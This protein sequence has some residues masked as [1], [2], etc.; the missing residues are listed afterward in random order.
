MKRL[1]LAAYAEGVR[2]RDRA[3]LGRAI[4]LIESLRADDAALAQALLA[5]LLPAT[6]RAVRVGLSG[7][8]GVGKSTFL[9][10]LGSHLLAAGRK[11]A[12]L[13]V[14]PSSSRSGGSILGDKT[15]MPRLAADEAAFVR[16]SP[17]GLSLGGVAR[18]TRE[19]L[20]LCEAA[21]HDVVL[22]ETVGVGQSEVAVADMVDVFVVLMLPGAGD[23]LQ[24]IKKGILEL[25]DLVVVNK[26]DGDNLSRAH[27]AE[28]EYR[29]AL[30]YASP[31]RAS[32]RPVVLLAS[33]LTGEGVPAVWQAIAERHRALADSGEL[34]A[35]RRAQRRA[36]FWSLV[37]ERLLAAFR[38][39]PQVAARLPVIE[40]RLDAGELVPTQAA[41]ELCAA[42]GV[43][44]HD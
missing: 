13:A 25:A 18:R 20:L 27:L 10:A 15:R 28:R 36:W 3:V 32:F 38:A 26:A 11:V 42:F 2:R 24:G 40:A 22:V 34:E 41:R 8:P 39:D 6:G 33:G 17:S 21:G 14:D 31:R 43:D 30:R 12:V 7:V 5:E 4:T 29:A 44:G 19:S 23:E 37:E 35:I 1:S 9:D 16:P